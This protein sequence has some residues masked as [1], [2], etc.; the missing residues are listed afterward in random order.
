MQELVQDLHRLREP[1]TFKA[2][3]GAY[4]HC[5]DDIRREVLGQDGAVSFALQAAAQG[6]CEAARDA[7]LGF[8][9][10][11]VAQTT[12]ARDAAHYLNSLVRLEQ[13]VGSVVFSPHS[14]LRALLEQG[15]HQVVTLSLL[16][17]QPPEPWA[18][19]AQQLRAAL[20]QACEQFDR[21]KE[22]ARPHL[23]ARLLEVLRDEPP[24]Y[25]P[26]V[27]AEGGG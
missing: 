7:M 18:T 12:A 24:P 17:K 27:P 16:L 22:G 21:F 11:V 6:D 19:S 1:G 13:V 5:M 26:R 23:S 10:R 4:A 25:V 20:N 3:H 14:E 15:A 9:K 2:T 8:R